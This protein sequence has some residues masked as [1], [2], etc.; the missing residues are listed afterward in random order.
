[1]KSRALALSGLLVLSVVASSGAFV[2][3]ATGLTAQT[4]GNTESTP[5]NITLREPSSATNSN[6]AGRSQVPAIEFNQ[7]ITYTNGTSYQFVITDEDTGGAITTTPPINQTSDDDLILINPVP[8]GIDGERAFWIPSVTDGVLDA[9][10][11]S[12]GSVTTRGVTNLSVALVDADTGT[13]LET[14]GSQPYVVG[15]VANDSQNS[16]S[17]TIQLRVNRSVLPEETSLTATVYNA[18]ASFPH[19]TTDRTQVNLTYDPGQEAF[20]GAFEADEVSSGTFSLAVEGTLPSPYGTS[21]ERYNME[22]VTVS[23]T[24]ATQ[25]EPV[26]VAPSSL[27]GNGSQAEPYVITNASELQAMAQAP[28]AHYT[29]GDDIDASET[30]QWNNGSGFEPIGSYPGTRQPFTGSFDGANHTITGLTIARPSESNVGLFGYVQNG[31]IENVGVVQADVTGDFTVGGLVGNSDSTTVQRVGVTGSISGSGTVGGIIGQNTDGT[32]QQAEVRATVNGTGPVGGVVGDNRGTLFQAFSRASVSGESDTGGVVGQNIGSVSQATGN[33]EVTGAEWTGGLVGQN[34]GTVRVSSM[35]GNVTG[36]TDVG[37]L[38]GG[39]NVQEALVTQSYA[40]A[41]VSGDSAVGG[42]LGSNYNNGNVT[43][44]Y[45]DEEVTGQSTS[46]LAGAGSTGLPTSAMTGEAARTNMTAFNFSGP[47]QVRK[48]TYPGLPYQTSGS[49]GSSPIIVNRTA[50]T[51]VPQSVDAGSTETYTITAVLENVSTAPG[52]VDVQL[53]GFDVGTADGDV[54]IDYTDANITDGTLTVS[55]S[56]TATAPPTAGQYNVTVTEIRADSDSDETFERQVDTD[57]VVEQIDVVSNS[58]NDS[59]V[60]TVNN[61]GPGD[62]ET[63][64]AAVNDA[65]SGDTIAVKPSIYNETVLIQKPLT[66]VAASTNNTTT[67]KRPVLD[68]GDARFDAIVLGDGA[69][70]A[71]VRGLEIRNYRNTGIAIN[72]Q[73]ESVQI[74]DNYIHNVNGSVFP[75]G[76]RAGLRDRVQRNID[77]S[78]NRFEAIGGSAVFLTTVEQAA[79]RN[80]TIRGSTE[81]SAQAFGGSSTAGISIAGWGGETNSTTKEVLVR[82]NDIS[83]PFANEGIFV[84]ALNQTENATGHVR[85]VYIVN[86]SVSGSAPGLIISPQRSSRNTVSEV[87]VEQTTFRGAGISIVGAPGT[88][89]RVRVG[90]STFRNSS[91]DAI[92]IASG[93]GSELLL[94]ENIISGNT[95]AGLNNSG[96]GI[97]DARYNYWGAPDGPSGEFNGTGDA[98]IG[99]AIVRP[100]YEDQ[101]LTTLSDSTPGQFDIIS[102]LPSRT[103]TQGES[104]NTTVSIRNTG[105]QT[106]EKVVLLVIDTDGDGDYTDEKLLSPQLLTLKPNETGEVTLSMDTTNLS[107]P[108][109][110]YSIAVV[111]RGDSDAI[112]DV[113]EAPLSIEP[114][115]PTVSANA[116]NLTGLEPGDTVTVNVTVDDVEDVY[117][118]SGLI[119]YNSSVVQATNISR[120]GL[121]ARDGSDTSLPVQSINNSTGTIDFA[122]TRL[123]PS[124]GINGSGTL[125]QI[126]FQ[127][128]ETAS[129]EATSPVGFETIT[130]S[131][132][133]ESRIPVT[134]EQETIPVSAQL[135]V[136][137]SLVSQVNYAGSPIRLQASATGPDVEQIEANIDTSGG[138]PAANA[139]CAGQ[140]ACDRPVSVTPSQSSWNGTG[141]EPIP[142][143]VTAESET[144]ET[145]TTT[146]TTEI[147]IAGDAS[148]DGKVDIQDGV[149]LGQ[150]WRSTAGSSEYDNAVDL[151]NDGRVN[152]FDA[153]ILGRNWQDTAATSD[154]GSTSGSGSTTNETSS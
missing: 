2:G 25:S 72:D 38:I 39:N 9:P 58:T 14:T 73:H 48:D 54:T 29:L 32:V 152:I 127:V 4:A 132:S 15:Y 20:V 99:D 49:D 105:E 68:G 80:N 130:L 85:Q 22:S 62:Y 42:L 113:A 146:V 94:R 64:Q 97:V 139:S 71:T 7:S 122:I 138:E 60:L 78:N 87:F 134:T 47:W 135:A 21:F 102:D 100:F 51:V 34:Q 143:E 59:T 83:G 93:N 104:F 16:T 77:I 117:A 142:V 44:S 45:W 30:A 67:P 140:S 8:G 125:I 65:S 103:V 98:V 79:V 31:T 36:T 147:R 12:S 141:Y 150:R 153:V 121:L 112:D 10:V 89:E 151:N 13:V 101:N 88:V 110:N 109:G 111:E 116:N 119:Q 46:A 43:A 1:M 114:N 90:E 70:T 108:V 50:S 154:S 40:A 57:V 52:E 107:A 144:G 56:I 5:V 63:I 75:I 123:G 3:P 149:L 145:V 136:N 26:S 86:N 61:D 129:P 96:T 106:A 126:R 24:T 92:Q 6:G 55:T 118:A 11:T 53:E 41:T 18:N 95:G 128:S 84:G 37:G 76:V 81:V 35:T 131:D 148:G 120:G 66:V 23:D 137:A 124:T 133:N 91:T 82:N 28:D 115:N 27:A 33:V 69:T 74:R 17:G 19:E